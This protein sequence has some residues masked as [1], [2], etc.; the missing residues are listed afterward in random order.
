MTSVNYF[1][2]LYVA[3]AIAYAFGSRSTRR[4]LGIATALL[5]A[6]SALRYLGSLLLPFVVPLALAYLLDPLLDWL[7][8]RGLTRTR[9]VLAVYVAFFCLLLV[10][11]LVVLPPLFGEL[12][13]MVGAL[14]AV[15]WSTFGDAERLH[16]WL[17]RRA[18]HLP[19]GSHLKGPID[20]AMGQLDPLLK[21]LT[22]HAGEAASW[23][24][25]QLGG[26]V[27]WTFSTVSGL[28]WLVLLPLNLW[29][30]LADF[31]RLRLRLWHL[32][33]AASR[34]TV[35]ALANSINAAL[36]SY[37]RG[38]AVLCTLVG[39]AVSVALLV[40][41]AL[42]GFHYALI[43]GILAGCTYFIPFVGGFVAVVLGT[44]AIYFTGTGSLLHAGI[45]CGVLMGVSAVFDNLVAP[46]IIG[47]KTGLHPL[48]IMLGVLVGGKVAGMVGIILST[49][50]LVCARIVLE[51]FYPALS[52]PLPDDAEPA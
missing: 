25:T 41:Q 26:V 38:Y 36:G 31:D 9:A 45:G 28:S 10:A 49:P 30:C 2:L 47:D 14:K 35:A 24:G 21:Q 7:E 8:T 15:D 50:A 23:L 27:S 20:Q 51:H 11:A 22:A 3:L 18:E 16:G 34:P 33:P 42:F 39:V 44:A 43:I 29:Y 13:D 46:R 48:W 37:A 40:M 12:G 19:L 1:G 32:V 5:L 4:L 52:E 6:A 17:L